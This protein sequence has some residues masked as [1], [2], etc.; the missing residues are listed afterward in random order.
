MAPEQIMG[1]PRLASDQ[2]ALGIIVYEWLS[3]QRP[4]QGTSNEIALQQTQAPPPPL[5]E[6]VPTISPAVEEVVMTALAKEPQQRFASI[7]SFASALE[8]ASWPAS[9]LL[10]N[11][12]NEASPGLNE[13][14]ATPSPAR[15][16]IEFVSHSP[17]EPVIP[18][19]DPPYTPTEPVSAP[20]GLG[21]T[22]SP[23]NFQQRIPSKRKRT[24]IFALLALIVLIAALGSYFPIA[25][26][27]EA[28]HQATATAIARATATAEAPIVATAHA[29]ATVAASF[30]AYNKAVVANGIMYG[31]DV[32]HTR[33]NPYE[34][35]INPH[36]VS[37]L[38]QDWTASA[39]NLIG[40]S[41]PAIAN[42][43]V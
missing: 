34:Q 25:A 8:Q 23:A 3:G 12:P 11:I 9:S 30:N 1:K 15:S 29:R 18:Q 6:K 36:N 43:V 42:G 14:T 22:P 33:Y 26:H 40:A 39:G 2:H 20:P 32:Q 35:V 4:F 41:S 5:R 27:N 16:N 21:T 7:K 10:P 19:T 17:T 31:F 38:V 13:R 28:N 37:G 24:F